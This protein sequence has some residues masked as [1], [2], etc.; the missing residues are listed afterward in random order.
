MTGLGDRLQPFLAARPKIIPVIMSGGSGTRLWPLSTETAPKQFHAL[1]S[2]RTM[3]QDTVLRMLQ[4]SAVDFLPPVVICNVRHEALVR[5]QLADLGVT[6]AAIVLEPFG[7]NT[8]AV[9][10]IAAQIAA[11]IDPEA[12]VLLLPADHLI[13]DEDAFRAAVAR[14][15]AIEGHLVTFGIEPTAPET[16]YGYIQRGTEVG[17]DLFTVARFAEKPSRAVAEAYISDGG[18]YWNGGIFLFPPEVLLAE[19]TIFRPD[20]VEATAA[21]LKGARRC[22]NR[23]VT[24]TDELFAQVPS[25]SI[26]FAIMEHTRLAVVAPCDAGWAD[27][28]SW[29]E[30]WRLGVR[31]GLG[32]LTRGEVVVLDTEDAMIWSQGTTVAVLGMKDILVVEANGAVIVLPKSRAQDVKTIVEAVGKMRQ[33]KLQLDA[34]A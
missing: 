28:G 33:A 25:D 9:A 20:I 26:D 34:V 4:P 15:A 14:G 10:V 5:E 19:M 11:E 22:E 27:V 7:R 17:E 29:S 31:D 18:Y 13:G 6:P 12:K 24:L 8:A 21:A 16:G 23:G 3:L 30:L 32:N 2:E 1:A